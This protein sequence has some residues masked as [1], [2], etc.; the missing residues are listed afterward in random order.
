MNNRQVEQKIRE[1]IAATKPKDDFD[2][3][4]TSC[5]IPQEV[6]IMNTIQTTAP[7]KP[8]FLKIAMP[9]AAAALIATVGGIVGYNS[10][11]SAPISTLTIDVNPSTDFVITRDMKVADVIA[12]NADSAAL[13]E[14][15]DLEG[16][17][18]KHAMQAFIGGMTGAGYL[19][20]TQNS[21]LFTVTGET[22][23]TAF[24]T[25]LMDEV[26]EVLDTLNF[27]PATIYQLADET[28]TALQSLAGD[29]GIS[30]G[31]ADLIQQLVNSDATLDATQLAGLTINDLNQLNQSANRSFDDDVVVSGTPNS[32][33]T[34]TDDDVANTAF[35]HASLVPADA[36]DIEF[37]TDVENGRLVYEVEFTANGI[38][39]E[40][41]IDP[42]TGEILH[43]ESEQ[44]D[45]LLDDQDDI[46]DVDDDMD[47]DQDDIDDLDDDMDDDQDDINDVD[48]DMDDDQDD[49][50]DQVT[51]ATPAPT[52]DHDDDNDDDDDYG[53]VDDADD[54]QDDGD[55]DSDDGDDD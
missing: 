35:N 36:T 11:M 6:T 44:D 46:D 16:A 18:V 23:D 55:D 52:V 54:D 39:Y 15:L 51:V 31:K 32:D 20:E 14:S 13:I 42:V 38:K 29:L 45:D 10:Y 41:D 4:L 48:D 27:D 37:D 1:A 53:D 49:D 22:Q 33:S 50:D 34:L 3:I 28:D 43:A 25:I 17:D 2:A 40:Y 19:T 30:L 7:R 8:K 24:N 5:N 21:V 9:C 12:G 47:D 26:N